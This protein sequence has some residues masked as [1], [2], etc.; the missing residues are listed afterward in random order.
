MSRNTLQAMGLVLLVIAVLLSGIGVSY[1][2]YLNRK[3]FAELEQL[4]K[5]RE[6]I[7]TDWGRLQLE[8]STLATY[9]RVE[10]TARKKLDMRI[11]AATE[12]MVIRH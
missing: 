2:K 12:I 1:T 7:A 11:P 9:V 5:Q 3:H 4:R 6:Q 8:Q 10:S